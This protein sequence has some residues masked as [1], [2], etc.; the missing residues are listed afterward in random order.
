MKAIFEK[1]LACGELFL[2]VP[3]L[4]GDSC[5]R[6]MFITAEVNDGLD[7]NT[8]EDPS[9]G[10]RVAQ[11]QADFDRFVTG[12]EI[13]IGMD[14]FDKGDNS[15]LSRIDPVQY[16]IWALRSVA[17]R[18][19]LRVFGAFANCDTFVAVAIRERSTLGGQK[20]RRWANAREAAR[21]HWDRLFPG[22]Q[23][24][25]GDHLDDYISEKA[26]AV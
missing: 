14:P 3:T 6:T 5:V 11:L 25:I 1:L 12:Q 22:Q 16:G 9:F 4:E 13:P 17:P 18:P 8:W 26:I 21:A 20:D 10:R 24:L 19:A 2:W 23:P 15:F 7:P